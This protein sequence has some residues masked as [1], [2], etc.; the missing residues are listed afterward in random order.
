MTQYVGIIFSNPLLWRCP[1]SSQFRLSL[2]MSN[3]YACA[4]VPICTLFI[5][6]SYLSILTTHTLSYQHN[7]SIFISPIKIS[8][9]SDLSLWR[10]KVS[11]QRN[12]KLAVEM[13]STSMVSQPEPTHR[14]ENHTRCNEC[15]LSRS[16]KS[17][18]SRQ[19]LLF[20]HRAYS[21]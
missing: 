1:Q 12:S 4:G 14:S 19:S 21:L 15:F 13:N 8:Q 17:Q 7:I 10:E 2:A 18:I 20:L 9:S 6:L 5:V 11:L 16:T 3:V